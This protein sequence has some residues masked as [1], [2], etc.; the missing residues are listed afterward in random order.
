V[1]NALSIA[2]FESWNQLVG[3]KVASTKFRPSFSLHRH[4]MSDTGYRLEYASSNR[5]KCKGSLNFDY[6]IFFTTLLTV[7]VV[8]LGTFSLFFWQVPSHVRVGD[9]FLRVLLFF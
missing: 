5:S 1:V 7:F 2:D 9:N 4:K 3:L 6:F 8:D